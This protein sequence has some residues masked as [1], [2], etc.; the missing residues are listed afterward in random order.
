MPLISALQE[1]EWR[2]DLKFAKQVWSG[3]F[4][5]SKAL[6]NFP[7]FA[8]PVKLRADGKLEG[9]RVSLQHMTA[10]VGGMEAQGEYRYEFGVPRPHRFRLAVAELDTALLEKLA[11]PALS[12]KGGIFSFG[13]TATP[14]WM[15]QLH[16]DGIVQVPVL[17]AGAI[18]LTNFRSRVIWDG[19]RVA[20]PDSVAAIGT[21]VVKSHVMVDL[22]GRAPAYEISSALTGVPWKSGTMDADIVLETNGLG[23]ET[24]SH[25]R[26]TGSFHRAQ[27]DRRLRNR[28][29]TV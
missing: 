9:A 11:S 4:E 21:G 10:S 25:M 1:G 15:K 24:L 28:G 18:E 16:A 12:R 6:V 5:L 14:D 2:G 27:R 23:T 29:R 7:G 13:K 3:N 20:L 8:E 17:H 22:G 26:S 19:V